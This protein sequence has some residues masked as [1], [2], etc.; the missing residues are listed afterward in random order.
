MFWVEDAQNLDG[1]LF[2][3][4]SQ[5]NCIVSIVLRVTLKGEEGREASAG[6]RERAAE[7][8]V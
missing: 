5:L 7:R 4:V 6:G 3:A 1:R 8:A 2:I